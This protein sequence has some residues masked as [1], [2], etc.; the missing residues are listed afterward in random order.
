MK[1]ELFYRG[2]E[3]DVSKGKW[4]GLDAVYKVR[5]PLRYRHPMLDLSV[6]RQRTLREADMLHS[7]KVA[8]VS[9]PHLYDVDLKGFTIV[10]EYVRGPRLKD[11]ISSDVPGASLQFEALGRGAA[12]LHAAGIMH[13][14]LT[15]ANVVGRGGELVFLDFGL[16]LHSHRVE[17][18]AV[19]LRLAKETITGAHATIAEA[20]LE[21]LF[22]GYL[23]EAGE[24]EGRKVLKQLRNI[25]RR[26]RYARVV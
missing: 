8:G 26:G 18:H 17:D 24:S 5:I 15:T 2:A 13:G 16:S 1:R 25:E 22:R 12:R 21:R 20:A 23:D 3:A 11:S 10:M 4:R 6:R 9:S 14:D 19:D 7:A